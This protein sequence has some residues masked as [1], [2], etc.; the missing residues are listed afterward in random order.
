MKKPRET[1][2]IDVSDPLFRALSEMSLEKQMEM[3]HRDVKRYKA[4]SS[5]TKTSPSRKAGALGMF[6]ERNLEGDDE[7]ALSPGPAQPGAKR[8]G[9]KALTSPKST[10]ADDSADE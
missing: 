2:V 6:E 1:G 3:L 10:P 9:P 4:R 7:M 5:E 8:P